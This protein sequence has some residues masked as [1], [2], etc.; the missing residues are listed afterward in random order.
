VVSTDG[1]LQ[2]VIW[3]DSL[4]DDVKVAI[5]TV[6]APAAGTHG[7]SY[8]VNPVGTEISSY[9]PAQLTLSYDG[10]D[11][12]GVA[13]SL[14]RIASYGPTGWSVLPDAAFFPQSKTLEATTTRLSIV[15]LV[16][17]VDT[18]L[19]D[20]CVTVHG[21]SCGGDPSGCQAPSCASAPN[22]CG[23][24]PGAS[25]QTCQDDAFNGYAAK[26]CF[27]PAAPLCFTVTEAPPTCFPPQDGG[28][29]ECPPP[30]RCA[31]VVDPCLGY[32]GAQ[33]QDCS[34]TATGYRGSCCFAVDAPICR[35]VV[36]PV[37]GFPS[38]C[39]PA[40][41]GCANGFEGATLSSCY[42]KDFEEYQT[43]CC[44]PPRTVPAK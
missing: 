17:L 20:G 6:A 14:L 18:A 16:V 37:S 24:Y 9:Y 40:S 34:D 5:A 8:K 1:K 23:A 25:V 11:L 39:G 13:P 35:Y 2:V 21:P 43:T 3:P 10:V 32:P 41:G 28:V 26:C 30:T 36:Y 15:A 27:A 4:S 7:D 22:I 44:F 33:F 42:L 19:G 12:A 38:P 31:T 29:N